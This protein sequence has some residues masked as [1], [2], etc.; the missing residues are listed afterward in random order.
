MAPGAE[1]PDVRLEARDPPEVHRL[2]AAARGG[3]RV[4]FGDLVTLHE[5]LV[6][7]TALAALGRPED[8]EEAAQEAFVIAW[9]RLAGFRGDAAFRTWL[10]RIAWHK[11]L[12]R[13][14]KRQRWW[15]HHTLTPASFEPG[16]VDPP[17]VDADPERSAVARD[18]LARAEI[19]I[20][21]LAPKLRDTLLLAAS[22]E[23][24]Y[25]EIASLL[26]VPIGTVKW[27]VSEARRLVR[28]KLGV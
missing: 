25:D 8:A 14:R 22:G 18:L 10:V 1:G 9:K 28:L 19:E 20:R 2:V 16:V 4:A 21:A 17:D 15:M 24:S 3:D 23:H 11:A 12:D 5:R 6:Y 27:R 7:R 13:R 26:G